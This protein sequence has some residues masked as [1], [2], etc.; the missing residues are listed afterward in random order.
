MRRMSDDEFLLYCE[1][2]CDSPRA[3][4]VPSQLERLANLAGHPAEQHWAERARTNPN[5][6]YSMDHSIIAPLVRAARERAVKP[7]GGE[8]VIRDNR[9]Y[10][11][12]AT[13]GEAEAL[14]PLFDGRICCWGAYCNAIELQ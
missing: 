10:V 12:C 4:F 5:G 8:F 2:H 9:F 6:I 1:T 3:G 11:V 7:S 14:L 13:E